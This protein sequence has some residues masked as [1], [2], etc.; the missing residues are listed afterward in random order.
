V[1]GEPKSFTS[2]RTLDVPEFAIEALKH[3]RVL[4][5]GERLKAGKGWQE[6]GLVF[7]TPIG[8]A[9]DYS[10]CRRDFRSLLA[11]AGLPMMRIHDLRHTCASLLVAQGVHLKV[12]Q[13]LLG[14]SQITLTA[15]T[16]SHVGPA[17]R[18]EAANRLQALL[19]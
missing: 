19:G 9:L 4:Q 8:T 1:Y 5:S 11:T 2:R 10:N 15:D 7:T 18:S 3:H 6:Q 17:V 16:Y 14:H 13:E 12:I